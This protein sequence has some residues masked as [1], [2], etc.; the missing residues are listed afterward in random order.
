[1][2]PKGYGEHWVKEEMTIESWRQDWVACGG[3]AN[4]DYSI[5]AVSGSSDAAITSA[6][7]QKVRQLATCMSNKGYQFN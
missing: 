6:I 3:R 7:N 5:D 2:H 4:G 1:M